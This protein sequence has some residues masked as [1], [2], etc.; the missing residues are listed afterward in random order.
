MAR[1]FLLVHKKMLQYL[2]VIPVLIG[3]ITAEIRCP[4]FSSSGSFVG[5]VCPKSSYCLY[6]EAKHSLSNGAPGITSVFDCGSPDNEVWSNTKSVE[7]R[8]IS[9]GLKDIFPVEKSSFCDQGD[10]RWCK[11][12]LG[13][14]HCRGNY[15]CKLIECR[16][17]TDDCHGFIKD[18]VNVKDDLKSTEGGCSG[19]ANIKG[20]IG[21]FLLLLTIIFL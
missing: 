1:R 5:E 19:A 16:C 21:F 10:G 18:G 2:W 6:T 3:S 8:H 12:T 20:G 17:N 14:E 11:V 4:T 15:D 7:S 9:K 13:P